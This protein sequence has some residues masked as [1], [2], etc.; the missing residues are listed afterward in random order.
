M[1]ITDRAQARNSEWRVVTIT[2]VNTSTQHFAAQDQYGTQIL[3]TL[4]GG[5]IQEIPTVGERWY[6][7][8]QGSDWRLENRLELPDTK[9]PITSMSPGDVRVEAS[10][11]IFLYG[12]DLQFNDGPVG[13][14]G[15]GAVASVFGR[16]GVVVATTGDYS[17]GQITG[18]APLASPTFTG[19]VTVP[20]LAVTTSGTSV[21][22]ATSDNSTKIAT[23][24]YVKAQGYITS[25]PVTSVFTRTGAV[26]AASGDY[27]VGQITAGT[28]HA[29]VI[30]GA[31]TLGSLA[32]GNA[33]QVLRSG[34]SGADPSW[35][36]ATYPA[37][38][39][40]AGNVP[41][42]DGTNFVSA[43]L[44]AS[45]VTSS[46]AYKVT[47]TTHGFTVGQVL[48][49][50]GTVYAL[51]KADTADNAEVVGIVSSVID[52]N[53]FVLMLVGEVTGLT[54]LTAGTTYFLDD[55][56]AG[57]LTAT[58]PTTN[59]HI[60]K[61]LGVA[62]STT[63]LAFNNM[64]GEIVQT[65]SSTETTITTISSPPASPS[66]GDR[67]IATNVPYGTREYV[68][69][70]GSWRLLGSE[71]LLWDSF[72][73]GVSLPAASI[74]TPSLDQ[75]Y[76][77]LKVVFRGRG[78]GVSNTLTNLWMRM[79]GNSG[80]NYY[81]QLLQSHG[82]T[83]ASSEIIAGS[84]V[85]C[86][87]LVQGSG[88]DVGGAIIWIPEYSLIGGFGGQQGFSATASGSYG[89]GTDTNWVGLYGGFYITA[90][91]ITTLTF[92]DGGA[93]NFNTT[94]RISVYGVMA[95]G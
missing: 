44:A 23:T 39:G 61:P 88:G 42:S 10:G 80:A 32:T 1:Q 82:T 26:V 4:H 66:D 50:N 78:T 5:V 89:T 47:Q 83:T 46:N 91:A 73:A 45:D 11:A 19:T 31:S 51:A 41:R 18:A 8:R 59:N 3:L 81:T 40:T 95:S 15:G 2:E 43:A 53:N 57:A 63:V 92:L 60:S 37:T 33:G 62:L 74:T 22:P 21:T 36:T 7:S 93:N 38:A 58:Q 6:V 64:R 90:G 68:Y 30:S 29:L 16:T 34:G 72:D 65:A 86:G 85:A 52:A 87:L 20:T 28:N 76:A 49:Y 56:T 48:L 77:H 69:T 55:V 9:L 67:W 79:N 17:V 70:G 27:S 84:A 54:G 71:V 75:T 25:A 12:T 94:T 14:G 35:S 24:A 13:S